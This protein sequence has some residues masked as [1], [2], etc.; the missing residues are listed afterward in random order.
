MADQNHTNEPTPHKAGY[1]KRDVNIPMIIIINGVLMILFIF[2]IWFVYQMY[3]HT[4]AELVNSEVVQPQLDSL[5][6][7]RI[8]EREPLYQYQLLDSEAGVYRIPV[9]SAMKML[10]IKADS[11]GP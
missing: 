11:G 7:A 4:Q 9:D 2:A 10:A 5:R 8:L 3:F 6:Q 1:E